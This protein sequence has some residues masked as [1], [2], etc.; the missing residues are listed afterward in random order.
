MKAHPIGRLGVPE[1]IAL[2]IVFLASDDVE[3][4][5]TPG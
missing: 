1:D 2:A 5:R 4:S 3:V